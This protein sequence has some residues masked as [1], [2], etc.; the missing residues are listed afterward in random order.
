[1]GISF[2]MTLTLGAFFVVS[3]TN[4]ELQRE[5][6]KERAGRNGGGTI[7]ESAGRGGLLSQAV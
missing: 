5:R 6:E 4:E 1:M 7:L 3:P 2:A